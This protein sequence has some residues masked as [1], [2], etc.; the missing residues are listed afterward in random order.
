MI[1]TKKNIQSMMPEELKLIILKQQGLLEEIPVTDATTTATF[2]HV[3]YTDIDT[4]PE[5]EIFEETDRFDY[6][7]EIKLLK[8]EIAELAEE[9]R[10]F[11][12]RI[13][14]LEKKENEL[15]IDNGKLEEKLTEIGQLL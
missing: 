5:K 6:E 11:I 8:K 9:N 3:H 13:E 14:W 4:E 12:E 10:E 15:L 7:Q 2:T 1:Y